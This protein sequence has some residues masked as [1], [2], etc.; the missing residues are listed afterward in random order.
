MNAV[1]E[2]IALAY[3]V[4][5]LDSFSI[6][7]R[8]RARRRAQRKRLSHRADFSVVGAGGFCLSLQG[9]LALADVVDV[10]RSPDHGTILESEGMDFRRIDARSTPVNRCGRSLLRV[11][12]EYVCVVATRGL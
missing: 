3:E 10:C 12:V 6:R 5:L 4:C 1:S 7:D 11:Q 8:S 9:N 2:A